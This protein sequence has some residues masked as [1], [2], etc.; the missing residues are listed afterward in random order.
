MESIKPEKDEVAAY[1]GQDRKKRSNEPAPAKAAKS[2]AKIGKKVASDETPDVNGKVVGVTRRAQRLL[3]LLFILVVAMSV[4]GFWQVGQ[5]AATIDS[6]SLQLRQARQSLEQSQLIIARLQGQVYQTDATMAQSGNELARAMQKQDKDLFA[7][8]SQYESLTA[9]VAEQAEAHERD[10]QRL[11]AQLESL[12]EELAGLAPQLVASKTQIDGLNTSTMALEGST[13]A[14]GESLSDLE[15]RQNDNL[16]RL[17]ALGLQDL[18][19]LAD[20]DQLQQDVLAAK[21]LAA[22]Q[23]SQEQLEALTQTVDSIDS[24]RNQLVQRFVTLDAKLNA[25]SGELNELKQRAP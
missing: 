5:Q 12:Q 19:L 4:L 18:G 17:E 8:G 16:D 25:L 6:M 24:T 7:L 1:Q 22:R 9:T 20:L 3:V 14:L 13:V 2:A 21:A 11:G 15:Q 10:Y 23:V